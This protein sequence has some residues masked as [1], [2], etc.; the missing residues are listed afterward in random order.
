MGGPGRAGLTEWLANS[1]TELLGTCQKTQPKAERPPLLA[2]PTLHVTRPPPSSG[3]PL[4]TVFPVPISQPASVAIGPRPAPT[5]SLTQSREARSQSLPG[6]VLPAGR[7]SA[8]H[9]GSCRTVTKALPSGG[10][11]DSGRCPHLP[12]WDAKPLGTLSRG[13]DGLRPRK[14]KPRRLRAVGCRLRSG[15]A[16]GRAGGGGKLGSEAGRRPGAWPRSWPS[17]CSRCRSSSPTPSSPASPR[18]A[19]TK[20]SGL[21]ASTT[22]ASPSCS[23]P[24]LASLPKVR[25]GLPRSPG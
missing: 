3:N 18:C 10:P 17:A 14:P 24:S 8:Q 15:A 2:T 5:A 6:V 23:S 22:S 7:G 9:G 13:R 21:P 25:G 4:V 12:G 20:P 16:P 11:R 19:A 1:W